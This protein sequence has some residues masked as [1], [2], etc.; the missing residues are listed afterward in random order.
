MSIGIAAGNAKYDK[1]EDILR[2]ADTAL[3]EVKDK[4]PW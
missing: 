1:P 2:N 3:Y 4:D